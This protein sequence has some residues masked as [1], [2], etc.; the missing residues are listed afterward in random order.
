MGGTTH[1]ATATP[2]R[3][4][5]E[6][7]ATAIRTAQLNV[8]SL[9]SSFSG[10]GVFPAAPGGRKH[11]NC[12]R[13][14]VGADVRASASLPG[15]GCW[16]AS[17]EFVDA[18]AKGNTELVPTSRPSR[19]GYRAALSSSAMACNVV[20]PLARIS[21]MIGASGA[22]FEPQG[23]ARFPHRSRHTCG[24]SY[25]RPRRRS[26]IGY[27]SPVAGTISRSSSA[28]CSVLKLFPSDQLHS[29]CR[30]PLR[31]SKPAICIRTARFLA[32][33]RT[34]FEILRHAMPPE[35]KHGPRAIG[36]PR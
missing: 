15:P 17:V 13:G 36:W 26:K 21:T 10:H 2:T 3:M 25:R 5:S 11:D 19:S 32:D 31:S 35:P 18:G 28:K 4:P 14:T 24:R 22:G 9:P 7:T 8:L 12:G 30:L 23:V 34:H 16:L 20:V 27:A 33:G 29:A 6:N 1:A